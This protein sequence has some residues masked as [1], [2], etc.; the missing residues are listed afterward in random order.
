MWAAHRHTRAG[1]GRGSL[2][3]QRGMPKAFANLEQRR[4]FGGLKTRHRS[5][6][7]TGCPLPDPPLPTHTPP[8][9]CVRR[10]VAESVT[11]LTSARG[12]RRDHVHRANPTGT[13]VSTRSS[14]TTFAAYCTRVCLSVTQYT[15]A[16]AP[17]RTGAPA[18]HSVAQRGDATRTGRG[19]VEPVGESTL[20]GKRQRRASR[21][22]AG[23]NDAQ[24]RAVR[25]QATMQAPPPHSSLSPHRHPTHFAQRTHAQF[26]PLL[27]HRWQPIVASLYVL[28]RGIREHTGEHAS[29]GTPPTRGVGKSSALDSKDGVA[30]CWGVRD[31]LLCYLKGSRERRL[32]SVMPSLSAA[33]GRLKQPTGKAHR[34]QTRWSFRWLP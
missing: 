26:L 27:P 3:A 31:L 19:G 33:S 22:A 23:T 20:L 30:W 6:E 21:L 8:R 32:L 28:G 4:G 17:A 13:Y 11:L 14:E 18:W 2:V 25:F 16:V 15:F 10:I 5:S 24:S 29:S 7:R 12:S 1:P 9:A 34:A